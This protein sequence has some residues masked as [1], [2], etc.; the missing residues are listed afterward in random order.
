[1]IDELNTLVAKHPAIGF[2]QAHY[3]LRLAGRPWNHKRVYRI[4]T[5]L[6]LN[7]RRRAKKRLPARVKQRLFQPTGP[8]QVWSLDYIHDSL[9]NGRTFRMLNVLDDYN[10]QVLRIE[11]DT[12][13]PARRVVR[14]LEQLE[15]SRGLPSMIR[16]DNGPEFISQR[17]DTWC[18]DRNITLAFI[19]PGKPTQNAYVERLNGSLRRELLNAYVFRTLDEVREKAQEWQHDYNHRR[20]HTSL[21]QQPP[22]SL[23]PLESSTSGPASQWGSLHL[24]LRVVEKLV[25][26]TVGVCLNA[27]DRQSLLST[28]I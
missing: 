20:P 10:R 23:L 9:W 6:G 18:K 11:A 13:L 17:L 21:G 27:A 25:P 26:K 12:C 7:I 14:V 28:P 4:Y 15:E 2:W 3:R 16:V 22:A 24:D 1:V 5:A 8:N 19:Q